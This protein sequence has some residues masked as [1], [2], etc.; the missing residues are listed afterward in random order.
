MV[1]DDNLGSDVWPVE[2]TLSKDKRTLHITYDNG[3][4]FSYT[5][6]F[7][8]VYSPSAEV[9]GHG[10]EP[11]KILGGKKSVCILDIVSIG[12]YAI[13]LKFDDLHDTGIYSWRYLVELGQTYDELWREYLQDLKSHGLT[14]S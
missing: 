5:S 13:K 11:R 3:E 8:R 1:D 4:A 6:E 2:I 12:N 7:L 9:K 14:R 10:S